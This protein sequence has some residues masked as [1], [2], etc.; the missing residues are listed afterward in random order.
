VLLYVYF[1]NAI[2]DKIILIGGDMDFNELV[3][4]YDFNKSILWYRNSEEFKEICFLENYDD[5]FRAFS[6]DFW[7]DTGIA[8]NEQKDRNGVPRDIPYYKIIKAYPHEM[9][10]KFLRFFYETETDD[11]MPEIVLPLL[12][13]TNNGGFCP[14]CYNNLFN[15][16]KCSDGLLYSTCHC[17]GEEVT[18]EYLLS[19]EQMHEQKLFYNNLAARLKQTPCPM[20]ESELVYVKIGDGLGYRIQCKE[21]GYCSYS[22]QDT[23]KDYIKKK[24]ETLFSATAKTNQNSTKCIDFFVNHFPELR[25]DE[26]IINTI[27]KWCEDFS[28]DDII[29]ALAITTEKICKGKLSPAENVLL[30]YTRGILNYGS[31]VR[32]S[33]SLSERYELEKWINEI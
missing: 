16:E 21:C 26:Y 6:E 24:S 27:K 9:Y 23:Y 14:Y 18:E 30:S 4:D 10:F 12:N 31:P 20:C 15:I 28:S 11:F 19:P 32:I 25:D 3:E 8:I 1:Y 2:I 5:K 13:I 22:L 17:C 33:K 29:K 7:S